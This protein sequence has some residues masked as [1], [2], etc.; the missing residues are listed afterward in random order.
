MTSFSLNR[1]LMLTAILFSLILPAPVSAFV[2][3]IS[4]PQPNPLVVGLDTSFTVRVDAE[5]TSLAWE[6]TQIFVDGANYACVNQPN[7]SIP[8]GSSTVYSIITL[9]VL[10][11][12]D[13][14]GTYTLSAEDFQGLDCFETGSGNMATVDIQVI[15]RSASFTVEKD[16]NQNGDTQNVPVDVAIVCTSGD[17]TQQ[18]TTI[19]EAQYG[20]FIVEDILPDHNC[21]ITESV[22]ENYTVSYDNG[23]GDIS[24]ES[25]LYVDVDPRAGEYTCT[26]TNTPDAATVT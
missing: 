13:T 16:W 7:P 26:I 21:T 3:G 17:P 1:A 8:P 24:D 15:E 18:A 11:P 22:P 12:L 6:S 19:S 10:P 4:N 14:P 20:T 25:C 9:P 5:I 23:E 2:T